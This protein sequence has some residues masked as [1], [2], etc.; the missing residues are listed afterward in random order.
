MATDAQRKAFR[1]YSKKTEQFVLR[2][3]KDTDADIIARLRAVDN[4]T[5]Y[6]RKLVL[7]DIRDE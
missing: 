7:G 2:F 4:K 1:K 5:E 3:R 6:V